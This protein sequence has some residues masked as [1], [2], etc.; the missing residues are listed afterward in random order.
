MLPR[1]GRGDIK[2]YLNRAGKA[3]LDSLRSEQGVVAG[4]YVHG[5]RP[6]GSRRSGEIL[7]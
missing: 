5:N 7:E 6:S 3:G 4:L 1:A 2:I